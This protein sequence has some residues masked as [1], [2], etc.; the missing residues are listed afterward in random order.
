MKLLAA[1]VIVAGDVV[2][3]THALVNL[4]LSAMEASILAAVIVGL[5]IIAGGLVCAHGVDVARRDV[6]RWLARQPGWWN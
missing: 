2:L 6:E 1:A 3:T 4:D 5:G